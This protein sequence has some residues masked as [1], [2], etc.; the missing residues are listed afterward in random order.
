MRQTCTYNCFSQK[1]QGSLW[2]HHIYTLQKRV[3]GLFSEEQNH[4]H[5]F[6]AQSSSAHPLAVFYALNDIF[7]DFSRDIQ[8]N[9][10]WI[11]LVSCWSCW[12][13]EG[14]TI[15]R[16]LTI[17]FRMNSLQSSIIVFSNENDSHPREWIIMDIISNRRLKMPK[18]RETT[19]ASEK[20]NLGGQRHSLISSLSSLDKLSMMIESNKKAIKFA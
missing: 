10:S 20:K 8:K 11:F 4:N 19:A 9:S 14:A 13:R 6:C 15:F 2:I 12:W 18:E 16:L 1:N 3:R 17:G 5:F 7:S